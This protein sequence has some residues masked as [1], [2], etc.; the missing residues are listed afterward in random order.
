VAVPGLACIAVAEPL[1]DIPV[2]AMEQT[3]V[4]AE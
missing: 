2:A 1:A 4:V 3:A